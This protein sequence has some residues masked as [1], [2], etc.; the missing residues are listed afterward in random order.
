[1]PKTTSETS[2][3][4]RTLLDLLDIE[5]LDRDVFRGHN[6]HPPGKR[7]YGGLIAAQALRAATR[8]V[9]Q[10]HHVHS[11]HGYFLRP[12]RSGQPVLLHVD[13]IRDGRSFTTRRVVAV[14]EG[15][16]IFTLAS[17]FHQDEGGPQ[18]QAPPPAGV[19]EPDGPDVE[20]VRASD[21]LAPNAPFVMRVLPTPPPDDRAP[22]STWRVW[23]RSDGPLPDERALHACVLAYLTDFGAVWA[24]A[25]AVGLRLEE[26]MSASLDHAVWF[27]RPVRLDEWVLFDLRP[28]SNGGSRGLALGTMYSG[29]GTLGAT[30]TQEAVIR[31]RSAHRE[32]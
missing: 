3:A 30:V 5:R 16:A 24:S 25:R 12:G 14:Q 29:S 28:L 15:E 17:S 20:E 18:Y 7:L 13:R 11:L 27:H 2:T 9:D 22:D 32:V 21:A 19:P 1:M 31:E 8:T 10:D 6:A 26:T 4:L 23:A